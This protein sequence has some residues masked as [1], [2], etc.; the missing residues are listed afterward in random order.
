[1]ISK[2]ALPFP[3][4]PGTRVYLIGLCGTGMSSLAGLFRERGCT[5]A[6]SDSACFSPVKEMVEDLH[7]TLFPEYREENIDSFRPDFVV[8]GNVV[9]RG[10][11]EGERVLNSAIPYF[12]MAEALRIFFLEGRE[13][14]V[15]AGTH[16]KTTTTALFAHALEGAGFHPGWFIGGQPADLS[17]HFR[18]GQG[19]DFVLEGDEYESAFFDKKSKFFHYYPTTLVLKRLEYDHTDIF[20]SEAEYLTAFRH[21]LRQLPSQGTLFLPSCSPQ[22]LSLLPHSYSRT[23]LYGQQ[24]GD[25]LRASP[26]SSLFPLEFELFRRGERSGPYRLN[27]LGEY[28]VENAL[29]VVAT[30]LERG[31]ESDRIAEI[32]ASF[33][34]VKRRQEI[35]CPGPNHL[36][37]DDFGHHPTAL[38]ETLRSV[39][40]AFPHHRIGVIFEPSSWSLRRRSFQE[41]LIDS[42]RDADELFILDIRAK[43]K[44][45]E[46][47]RLDL[48]AVAKALE[49]SGNRVHL[50][51]NG[52]NRAERVEEEMELFWKGHPQSVTTIFSNG[53]RLGLERTLPPRI[54]P[55][56]G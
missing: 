22:A 30:L 16:G 6:G 25:D 37:V 10:H 3:L 1:M 44:V 8:V 55:F 28:N 36:L 5:V 51:L 34:G 12:S 18:V 19:R 47:E 38:K 54:R 2:R 49:S 33:R 14:I 52:E 26:L 46:G 7:V 24:Q 53:P 9:G 20:S 23:L 50:F 40:L 35:L 15:V 27:L 11:V 41:P 43:E 39:R 13:R 4:G 29:P 48:Q 56:N 21:L 42:L 31:V 17:P 32:L 45:P